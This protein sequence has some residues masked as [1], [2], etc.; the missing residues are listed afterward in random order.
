[1]VA[2][3]EYPTD[4]RVRREAET[5]VAEGYRVYVISAMP[6]TGRSP[7]HMG[8]VH[9]YEIPLTIR[10]GG[11][12]RYMYQYALFFFL[13][14]ALLMRLHHRTRFSL[15]HVHS[16]PDFQVFCASPFKVFRIPVL[17]DLHE[18]MPEILIARFHKSTGSIWFRL[19]ALVERLSCLF[20]DHVV[21]ANDGIRET[22]VSRGIPASHVT[23]VYNAY[24]G[25]PPTLSSDAV[26]REFGLPR[27]RLLVHAGGI[28][29]ERDLETLL[30]AVAR[31][32]SQPDLIVVIAGEGRPEYL[33]TL[34]QLGEDLH[35]QDRLRF[36]GRI[37]LEQA[38][39]L[40]ALSE[41]GVVTLESNPLTQLAW[42]TR[43]L[44]FVAFRRPLIVPDLPLIRRVLGDAARYY[45]PGDATSLAEQ[46]DL[47]FR[48]PES[49]ESK[50]NDAARACQRFESRQ[51]RTALLSICQS[52]EALQA[53]RSA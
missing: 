17:L 35:L 37:P 34:R 28:N 20:A 32:S 13:S 52:V 51:V 36:I 8:G 10:R 5:L 4:P 43:I 11:G 45:T 25:A 41:L 38:R 42:P 40:S 21:A 24:D 16:L 48:H 31:L 46:L 22:V 33:Q 1:M 14:S 30:R 9:L 12:L 15:I 27:G 19:A 29:A 7:A 26:R 53:A 3:T 49:L 44:E 50:V 2:Y 23:A 47:A 6:R 18:A 39:A